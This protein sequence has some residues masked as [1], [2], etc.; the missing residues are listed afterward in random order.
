[1]AWKIKWDERAS[2]D[3]RKISK[4]DQ[5]II[6]K[7]LTKRISILDDPKIFGKPLGGHLTGLWRYRVS[8]YRIVCNFKEDAMIIRVLAVGHRSKVYD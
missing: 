4:P 6:S 8:D 2:K 7:Y 3:F 1:M 5:I